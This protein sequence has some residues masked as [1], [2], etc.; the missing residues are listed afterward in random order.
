[1]A[2]TGPDFKKGFVDKVPAS[3]ADVG[4]TLARILQLDV[5]N[6]G[7]LVGRVLSEAMPGGKVPKFHAKTRR[8]ASG[9]NGL[10]TVLKYQTVGQ[11]SYFDA[12]GFPGRTVGLDGK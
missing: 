9:L 5:P 12:A 3:N 11:S 8:S 1:M 7:K 4:K 10:R 2:A 6:K